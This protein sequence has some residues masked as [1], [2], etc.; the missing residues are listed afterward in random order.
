M[1]LIV[2]FVVVVTGLILAS[3]CIIHC[4]LRMSFSIV[5]NTVLA[6]WIIWTDFMILANILPVL[7]TF[8]FLCGCW[9]RSSQLDGRIFSIS[10]FFKVCV[11]VWTQQYWETGLNTRMENCVCHRCSS[12]GDEPCHR[13]GQAVSSSWPAVCEPVRRNT[14]AGAESRITIS[15]RLRR[16]H[17]DVGRLCDMRLSQYFYEEHFELEPLSSATADN[18]VVCRIHRSSTAMAHV[19]LWRF[20][21]ARLYES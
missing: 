14:R 8:G 3:T 1:S 7:H 19:F 2:F 21:C 6:A 17:T 10:M 5:C 9:Y 20:D 12:T 16:L 11:C 15:K 4:V 18:D 13:H